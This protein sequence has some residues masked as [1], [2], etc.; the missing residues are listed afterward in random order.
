M[1]TGHEQRQ[2]VLALLPAAQK[3][4]KAFTAWRADSAIPQWDALKAADR[5]LRAAIDAATGTD[6]DSHER[7]AAIEEAIDTEQYTA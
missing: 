6:D 7:R 1:T 4:T 2:P 3:M 5:T